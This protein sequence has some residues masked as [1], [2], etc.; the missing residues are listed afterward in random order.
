MTFDRLIRLRPWGWN[1]NSFRVFSYLFRQCRCSA[2]WQSIL[3]IS[4]LNI[5]LILL[6]IS[7]ILNVVSVI[8]IV[9]PAIKKKEQRD[10]KATLLINKFPAA[11]Y[12]WEF[13]SQ[14]GGLIT[15]C[16]ASTLIIYRRNLQNAIK[17]DERKTSKALSSSC[18]FIPN[19]IAGNGGRC[20]P[21][22]GQL[23][24]LPTLW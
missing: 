10:P 1:L 16:F 7:A 11:K 5:L 8:I 15:W 6:I 22:W 18:R 14:E 9:V 12:G 19:P 3:N 21:Q 4:W 24:R 17:T 13:L 23:H 2:T 20:V